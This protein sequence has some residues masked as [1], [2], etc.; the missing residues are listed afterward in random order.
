M[1]PAGTSIN[2]YYSGG[3]YVPAGTIGYPA[4]SAT[5]IPSGGTI[6]I[7]NFYGST[8]IQPQPAP[9]Q[10]I[11]FSG[12]TDRIVVYRFNLYDGS[13]AVVSATSSQLIGQTRL[14]G[15]T[16]V[17][18]LSK[19]NPNGPSAFMYVDPVYRASHTHPDPYGQTYFSIT[20]QPSLAEPYVDIRI[21]DDGPPSL[22]MFNV[23]ISIQ[24]GNGAV[25]P[26]TSTAPYF[27][28]VAIE[29]YA[30]SAGGDFAACAAYNLLPSTTYTLSA[31]STNGNTSYS[32]PVSVTTNSR[33]DL[34]YV[35]Q[36]IYLGNSNWYFT[37]T[38][39]GNGVNLSSGPYG[40]YDFTPV[41]SG[42]GGGQ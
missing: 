26:A 24:L 11:R 25:A 28:S 19:N 2:E 36:N 1:V 14:I 41:D 27:Y 21:D 38:I 31:N 29:G 16:N 7:A 13:I 35:T 30:G 15:V 9:Y 39:T 5:T 33:G 22:A 20:H 18:Q 3:A 4:G 32:N 6:S 34:V 42:S 8:A 40:P 12:Y 17:A 23:L 10:F 37:Y